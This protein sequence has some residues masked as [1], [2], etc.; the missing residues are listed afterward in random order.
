MSKEPSLGRMG[1]RALQ[2]VVMVCLSLT[3]AIIAACGALE[4]E[5]EKGIF[6]LVLM[7]IS[8]QKTDKILDKENEKLKE[9]SEILTDPF[10]N[11]QK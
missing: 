7:V 5:W 3:G 4:G 1:F 8:D 2:G 9:L 11:K 10:E 6:G